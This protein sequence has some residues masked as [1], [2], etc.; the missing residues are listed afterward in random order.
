MDIINV[1]A[2]VGAVVAIVLGLRTLIKVLIVPGFRVAKTLEAAIPVLVQLTQV[3]GGLVGSL[4]KMQVDLSALTDN[5]VKLEKYVHEFK[6]AW[7]NNKV[8][9]DGRLAVY[10]LSL[11][12]LE[13][14]LL[15]HERHLHENHG[16]DDHI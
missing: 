4:Q 7:T 16:G 8:A 1:G 14:A 13:R 6:H 12:H 10:D 5:L 9:L 2:I 3:N 11:N 15:E